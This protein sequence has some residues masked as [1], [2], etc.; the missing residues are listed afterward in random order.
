MNSL[1][2]YEGATTLDLQ[3]AVKIIAHWK[4]DL[5][6]GCP[7]LLADVQFIAEAHLHHYIGMLWKPRGLN[8][9]GCLSAGVQVTSSDLKPLKWQQSGKYGLSMP[10]RCLIA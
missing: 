6:A 5:Y 8:A 2:E 3:T 4:G 10:T 9:S 7:R 1:A